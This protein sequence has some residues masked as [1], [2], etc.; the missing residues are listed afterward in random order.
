MKKLTNLFLS[1]FLCLTVMPIHDAPQQMTDFAT[2]PLPKLPRVE[3]SPFPSNTAPECPCYPANTNSVIVVENHTDQPWFITV[4]FIDSSGDEVLFVG[5]WCGPG[6]TVVFDVTLILDRPSGFVGCVIVQ[7][8]DLIN[9]PYTV[10]CQ[11]ATVYGP[12]SPGP[13]QESSRTSPSSKGTTF[14]AEPVHVVS[15]NYVHQVKDLS[16]PGRELGIDFERTYNSS[17]S[18]TASSLGY[19]WIHSYDLRVF[20]ST[21]GTATVSKASPLVLGSTTECPCYPANKSSVVIAEN[22]TSQP[23]FFT[24]LFRDYD[25]GD[26]CFIGDWAGP[27]GSVVIDAAVFEIIPADFVGCVIVRKH[28][29]VDWPWMG[30]CHPATVWG[31]PAP[32]PAQESSRNSPSSKGTSFVAE[33]VNVVFGNYIHQ[34]KDLS[35]PGR[36]PSISLE[37]TYNSNSRLTASSLGYGWIHSYDMRAGGWGEVIVINE[38]GRLDRFTPGPDNEYIPPASVSNKLVRNPDWTFTLEKKDQTKYNFNTFGRLDT[39]VDKNGNTISF[40]YDTDGN[41]TVITDTVGRT[42]T[43]TYDADNRI[44]QITDPAGRTITYGYDA[45]GDLTTVTDARGKTTTYAYDS[46]HRL[47]SIT[48][49][50]GHVLITNVYNSDGRVVEQRNA[51]DDLTTFSYDTE[52]SQTTVTDPLENQTIYTYDDSWRVTSETDALGYTESYTYDDHFNRASANDKTGN[53]TYY[54]Y[55][56]MSNVTVITDTLGYVT[57]M[58]YDAN[59][60]LTSQTDALGHTTTFDYDAN[61]NLTS[62]TDPLGHITSFAYDDHG[63]MINTT[64]ANGHTTTF[65]Y[66]Q[67]GNQTTITDALG[68]TTSFTYDIVGRNT[69][70]T[71]ANGNTTQYTYDANDNLISVTDALGGIISYAYDDV[72]NRISMTD[73]NDHITTYAYDALNRPIS[74]TDPLTHT[75]TYGYDALGNRISMEDAN[76]ATTTYDYDAVNRLIQIDYPDNTVSYSYDPVGNRTA[77]TDTTGTTTYTHDALNRLTSVT[78]PDSQTVSYQYNAVGNRASMTYPDGKTITYAY[79]A[80]NRLTSVTD[81]EDKVTTYSYDAVGNRIGISYPNGT[82]ASYTFDS[83][84]RLTAL[85]NTS[86]VHGTISSFSYTLDKVGN[87]TQVAEQ[88]FDVPTPTPTPTPTATATPTSTPT[89]TSTATPSLKYVYLPLI[90]KSYSLS[91]PKPISPKPNTSVFFPGSRTINY[92]YDALNRLTQAAYSDGD[93]VSYAYDPMGN[94]TSMTVNGT[95]TTYTYDAADRLLSA[96]DT[97]FTWDSNGNMLSRNSIT[98]AYDYANRLVKV[99]S[100]TTTVEFAYDG[101]GKRSSKMVNGATANYLYDV[102]ALLPVV[103]SE[104]ANGNDTLYTYGA[105]LMAMT[106]PTGAQTYYH[107]DGLGSVCNLTNSSGQV[108]AGYTYDA[109]GNLSVMTGSSDNPFRFTGQQTDDVTGLLYLRARYYDPSIG[110]FITK[111]PFVGTEDN[112]QSL[113]RYAYAQ[114]NPVNLTD[115]SGYSPTNDRAFMW[116]NILMDLIELYGAIVIGPEPFGPFLLPDMIPPYLIPHE[117]KTYTI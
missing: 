36:G 22:H 74:V 97:T 26:I 64:D 113:H 100:G 111:D 25:V 58:T 21:G 31:P 88:V 114:N 6:R 35:I 77:M 40:G 7:R 92:T 70:Q 98:Y 16:I 57:T 39:I 34:A 53:T 49:P 20:E 116:I 8:H 105:E 30:E 89:P 23:W 59:N 14:V 18:L 9:D 106:D 93:T 69:S 28:E 87:R 72:G 56:E 45:N 46:D 38:D 78:V 83:A 86:P 103:L 3:A 101:D 73:A 67:Y 99:I 52:G 13:A 108:I 63:Q 71:D 51:N 104:S 75:T 91:Y 76:G 2:N 80:A 79:D 94:R 112:P 10:E 15:G 41:L 65:A 33:P 66:D 48:D 96:G 47:V 11:E 5:D 42:I 1:F 62:T 95:T 44:T 68:N 85:T 37:R 109:F 27:G 4:D 61:G 60:N 43:L 117:G 110:R 90:L 54:D 12:S 82:N 19:G 29:Q 32:E 102:N 50:Y 55:D 84:N 17:S 24:F 81:W 115:P 107:Y